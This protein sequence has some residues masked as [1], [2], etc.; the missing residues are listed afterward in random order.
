MAT[1][2]IL[3]AGCAK[4]RYLTENAERAVQELGRTNVIEK[5]T[6]IIKMLEFSPSALPALAIDGQVVSAGT[7]PSPAQIKGF[8]EA[9]AGMGEE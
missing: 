2:Q 7:L 3:G 9:S 8:L 1:I 6:D 4:C 5:V